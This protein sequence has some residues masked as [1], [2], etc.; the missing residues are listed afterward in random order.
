MVLLGLVT[1]YS[2]SGVEKHLSLST[3]HH[4]ILKLHNLFQASCQNYVEA[5]LI[6]IFHKFWVYKW[7]KTDDHVYFHLFAQLRKSLW[8]EF[9]FYETRKNPLQQSSLMCLCC[10]E[11]ISQGSQINPE[12]QIY[13]NQASLVLVLMQL[14]DLQKNSHKPY[15]HLQSL[16]EVSFW[17]CICL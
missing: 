6:L 15:L 1:I 16:N 2:C 11:L 10:K 5:S 14:L 12:T 4:V 3:L 8:Q 17:V 9:T 7:P 13:R